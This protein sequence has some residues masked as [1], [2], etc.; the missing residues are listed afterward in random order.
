MRSSRVRPCLAA[1]AIVLLGVIA[2][3]ASGDPVP[4][5]PKDPPA[6]TDTIELTT[7]AAAD[8]RAALTTANATPAGTTIHLRSGCSYDFYDADNNW[9]GPNALPPIASTVT[10]EGHG[11]TIARQ[12]QKTTVGIDPNACGPNPGGDATDPA[13]LIWL[14]CQ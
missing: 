11:S 9:Y 13:T 5:D 1:L 10:I 2:A 6:G 7:C 4:I 8:L 14:L 12:A 3:P